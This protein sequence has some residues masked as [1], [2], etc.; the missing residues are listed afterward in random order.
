MFDIRKNEQDLASLLQDMAATEENLAHMVDYAIAYIRRLLDKYGAQFPRRTVITGF[1]PVDVRKIARRDVKVHHDRLNHFLGTNVKGSNKD[2]APLVCT[3]FD[4]LVL[5]RNDGTCRVISVPEKE[6]IG[7]TKYVMLWNKDQVYSILYRDRQ[8]GTWFV[9]RFTL[10]QFTLGREYT[11]CNELPDRNS[12]YHSGVVLCWNWSQQSRSYLPL[13]RF[14][15]VRVTLTRGQGLQTTQYQYTFN[16]IKRGCAITRRKMTR[17]V[18]R[19]ATGDE[20]RRRAADTVAGR[21]TP[22]PPPPLKNR[23]G[24]EKIAATVKSAETPTLAP[25]VTR[26]TAMIRR[27]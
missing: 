17:P 4:R 2:S 11:S 22:S 18:R 7:P 24:G 6:Y 23:A 10:E 12:L 3:E 13:C 1:A 21:R 14:R 8:E 25:T 19:K 26:R 9:K 16:G 5:L 20:R 15:S 27:R